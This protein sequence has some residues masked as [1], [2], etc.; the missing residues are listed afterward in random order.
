[1]TAVINCMPA[2]V[3]QVGRLVMVE[4]S[5][6]AGAIALKQALDDARLAQENP[7]EFRRRY[8]KEHGFNE[9]EE[10]VAPE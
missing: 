4:F 8:A 1:M 10:A 5:D 6:N 2:K 3:T 9:G 7:E